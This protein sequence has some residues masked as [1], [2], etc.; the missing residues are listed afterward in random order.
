MCIP[1][2][3]SPLVGLLCWT[4]E[5]LAGNNGGLKSRG[6]SPVDTLHPSL[7]SCRLRSREFFFKLCLYM[8]SCP[9]GRPTRGSRKYLLN[10]ETT[11]K[12]NACSIV[13]LHGISTP[14]AA[15]SDQWKKNILALAPPN[16]SLYGFDLKLQLGG[17]FRASDLLKRSSDLLNCINRLHE[18]TKVN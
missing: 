8:K 15:E 11:Q 7:T 13:Y 3:R 18:A 17:S 4:S 16:T 14:G 9:L 5:Q 12:L 2:T 10:Y 6:H 1:S